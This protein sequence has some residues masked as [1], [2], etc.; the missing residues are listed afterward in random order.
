MTGEVMASEM[1]EQPSVL[2]RLIDRRRSTIRV[3]RRALPDRPAGVVLVA[4]GSSDNAAVYG[5][6]LLG[7]AT[8]RPVAL[9]APSL[10]TLYGVDPR[11][12]G[13]LAVVV[14]QSGRTP[15]MVNVARHMTAGGAHVV[16]VTNDETSPLATVSRSVVHLDAGRERAVPATKTFTAQLLGMALIAD[17]VGAVPWDESAWDRLPDAVA[18]VLDDA[19]AVNHA[20]ASVADVPGLLVGGRG[21]LL[22]TA[23]ETALKLKECTGLLAQGY[24]T[25]DLRHGPIAVVDRG[26]PVIVLSSRGPT[27]TDTADLVGVLRAR[28]A[29]LIEIGQRDAADIGVPSVAEGLAPFVSAVRGQQLALATAR[30]RGLDPDHPEGLSKITPTQ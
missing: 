13:W 16:A 14:S 27:A 22:A 6:Y 15:E 4:R 9:A 10:V 21:F 28:G 20:A 29:R 1:A 7:M 19:I 5:R 26:V 12:D 8:R 11:V 24:S 3:L 30:R 25:A 23:Y 2:G 17:A 18:D